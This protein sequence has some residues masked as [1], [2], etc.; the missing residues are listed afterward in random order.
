MSSATLS[1]ARRPG[2]RSRGDSR[3]TPPTAADDTSFGTAA[4]FF[5]VAGLV[6]AAAAAVLLHG[7]PAPVLALVA[8][9]LIAAGVVGFAFF[10]VLYPLAQSHHEPGPLPVGRARVALERD[11]ALTLR[12]IKEL[13]FDRAMGKVSDADFAEMRDRLRQRALRLIRQLDGG[14]IYRQR[15]EA[16]LGERRSAGT[17]EPPVA[18]QCVECGTVNDPDARF[19]KRC[20]ERLALDVQSA[21]EGGRRLP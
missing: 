16:D 9:T 11:K 4:G 3:Q 12:A 18:G 13:E 8:F 14:A 20:G 10:R 19:C 5:L 21:G 7:R 15:I 1:N 2:G 17:T 6:V